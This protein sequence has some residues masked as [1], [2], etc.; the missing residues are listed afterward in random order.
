V[1]LPTKK[2]RGGREGGREG[3]CARS[4]VCGPCAD[5]SCSGTRPWKDGRA[6]SAT[7][8]CFR[9]RRSRRKYVVSARPRRP[10]RLQAA[11]ECIRTLAHT[12]QVRNKLPPATQ[13]GLVSVLLTPN[14]DVAT[15][16]NYLVTS[17]QP[18]FRPRG[19][20]GG[21]GFYSHQTMIECRFVSAKKGWEGWRGGGEDGQLPLC[22][23]CGPFRA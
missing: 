9:G 21:C 19:L 11:S 10:R 6:P 17:S 7:F 14:N 1:F 8:V 18:V 3:E 16:T 13:M 4:W 22:L 23:V 5:H 15:P 20:V 12:L 2:N